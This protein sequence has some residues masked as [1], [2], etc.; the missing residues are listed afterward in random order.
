MI[1]RHDKA[2][3]CIDDGLGGL[4]GKG[5]SVIS[6]AAL[7][8]PDGKDRVKPQFDTPPSDSPNLLG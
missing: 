7:I 4:K 3:S 5:F 2:S 8:L 6:I 1:D